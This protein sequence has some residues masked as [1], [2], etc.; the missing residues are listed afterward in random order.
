MG[1]DVVF[2]LL[3][4]HPDKWFSAKDMAKLADIS[5]NS[6]TRSL[7]RMYEQ[8]F[9]HRVKTKVTIKN[10][11]DYRIYVYRLIEEGKKE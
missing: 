1:Q 8:G 5:Y 7:L 4:K 9:V 10:K 6:S 11:Q 3:R 2:R